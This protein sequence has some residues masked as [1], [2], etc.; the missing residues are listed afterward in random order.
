MVQWGFTGICVYIWYQWQ[1]AKS[2]HAKNYRDRSIVRLNNDFLLSE[3]NIEAGR[4]YTILSSAVSHE[5]LLH[6][7]ANM[8]SFHAFVGAA[9]RLGLS[10]ASVVVV[11]AASAASCGLAQVADN[12]RTGVR[13]SALGASGLVSGLAGYVTVL[14]PRL[15]FMVFL[16]PVPIPLWVLTPA[17]LSW[18]LYNTG[19]VDSGIGHAGHVGG[20]L[21]GLVLGF[22]RRLLFR[23]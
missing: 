15:R 8:I 21:C 12:R 5:N 13:G 4:W 6:L 3:R 10:P 20:G 11:G 1:S 17:L 7:A 18:D 19:A 14:A 22:A 23:F 16:I 9:W 2:A